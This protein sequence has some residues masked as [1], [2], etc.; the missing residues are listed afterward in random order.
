MG[1]KASSSTT[2]GISR[3]GAVGRTPGTVDVEQGLLRDLVVGRRVRGS[4]GKV[5]DDGFVELHVVGKTVRAF[6]DLSLVAGGDYEFV[7]TSR[8]P[9]IVLQPTQPVTLPSLGR[10]LIEGG[11]G[12]ALGAALR[13]LEKAASAGPLHPVAARMTEIA[14]KFARGSFSA[15]DLAEFH[16]RLGHDQEARVQ[17]LGDAGDPQPLRE[18]MKALALQALRVAAASDGEP[19][20]WADLLVRTLGGVESENARRM[21]NGGMLALPLPAR[22][23]G[24]IRDARLFVQPDLSGG[25]ASGAASGFN[26]VLLLDL[27]SLGAV[28]ADVALRGT[29]VDVAIQV[30]DTE[31]EWVIRGAAEALVS[32]LEQHGLAVRS[33]SVRRAG[34]SGLPVSD[35]MGPP[36]DSGPAAR[37]DIRA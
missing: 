37:V 17:Q 36:A 12:S 18:T 35:L 31:A 1:I 30:T 11:L 29:E 10:A 14:D 25:A 33:W 27:T 6:T 13:S 23:D 9:R 2:S 19:P 3:Q 16:A 5:S 4:I 7:V 24:P 20:A 8:V 34:P 26:V 22:G 15:A 28:R 32:D 21:E